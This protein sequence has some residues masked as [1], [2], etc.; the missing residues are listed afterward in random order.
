[1]ASK[2]SITAAQ[3]KDFLI[4][5]GLDGGPDH[6]VGVRN[7]GIG[8]R[9]A[10]SSRV[11]TGT[12]NAGRGTERAG[13]GN[14]LVSAALVGIFIG[15]H[16]AQPQMAHA[17]ACGAANYHEQARE[18][19]NARGV[20]TTGNGIRVTNSS[21]N[22]ERVSSLFDQGSSMNWVEIGWYEHGPDINSACGHTLGSPELF[23]AWSVAN[24][25]VCDGLGVQVPA[26]LG[27]NFRVEDA[28]RDTI[29]YFVYNGLTVGNV[30]GDHSTGEVQT[31]AE[32]AD[33]IQVVFS[34]FFGLQRMG[35]NQM[36]SNWQQTDTGGMTT[37]NDPEYVVC[38]L[39]ATHVVVDTSC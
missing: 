8:G 28:N 3:S 10:R 6:R 29:W 21:V 17:V 20:R 30:N 33:D 26:G 12:G 37:N 39:S 31:N 38:I 13:L 35:S 2:R 32:R 4:A 5:G 27:N 11:S 15:I 22:C 18:D 7:R 23:I 9:S 34:E 14:A 1:V 36:Y 24:V 25:I 19:T 16:M